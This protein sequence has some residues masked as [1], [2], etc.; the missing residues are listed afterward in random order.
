M[1]TTPTKAPSETA[2]VRR[3]TQ[4]VSER[5]SDSG[6]FGPIGLCCASLNHRTA[7]AAIEPVIAK[8]MS[9]MNGDRASAESVCAGDVCP[10]SFARSL[11]GRSEAPVLP[12][13]HLYFFNKKSLARLAARAGFDHFTVHARRREPFELNLAEAAETVAAL[14]GAG[15]FLTL[16]ATIS[17]QTQLKGAT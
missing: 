2:I 3:P 1:T 4:R 10:G 17:T 14:L 9:H 8:T 7:N 12:S 16:T 6:S 13:P 11:L 5:G 15:S